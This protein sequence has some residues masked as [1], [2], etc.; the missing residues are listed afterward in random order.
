MNTGK[1]Y[2]SLEQKHSSSPDKL[3]PGMHFSYEPTLFSHAKCSEM[4]SGPQ[5][6]SSIISTYICN[7]LPYIAK[8][9]K[10]RVLVAVSCQNGD[11]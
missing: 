6:S 7:T 9:P 1:R 5:E 3:A 4:F 11:P 2:I 10:T 8:M